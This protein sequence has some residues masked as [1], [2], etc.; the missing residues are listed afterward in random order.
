[1]VGGLFG[2]SKD[3]VED[4]APAPQASDAPS[5]REVSQWPWE[6]QPDSAA[7]DFA[8]GHLFHHLPARLTVNGGVH[9]ETCL[10]AIGAIAGFA[11]QR[12]LFAYLKDTRDEA[13]LKQ[14]RTVKTVAGAEYY[15]GEPLNRMLVSSAETEHNQRL[16]SLAAGGAVGAGL[17]S[18]Q[19]PKLG[20]MFAHVAKTIGGAGAGL[21]SVSPDHHPQEP[22]GEILKMV[23]PLALA[24][25]AGRFPAAPQTFGAASLRHWPAIAARVASALILE[26]PST[27]D[28]R[29]ALIL[30]MEAAIYAS[31]LHPS[32]VNGSVARDGQ[33]LH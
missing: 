11:A 16:W 5:A 15:F 14:M 29:V 22:A 24:C 4:E 13:L 25:F 7:C 17:P 30:V 21:P 10:T 27:L 6:G 19:L 9:A 33:T 20:D 23:W 18:S 26:M 12:A 8:A 2:A 28:R 1:V 3:I 32:A 31:K